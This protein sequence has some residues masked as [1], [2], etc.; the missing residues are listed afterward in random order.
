[1]LLATLAASDPVSPFS[2]FIAPPR[3]PPV[4]PEEHMELQ[5]QPSIASVLSSARLD[6]MVVV[7]VVVVVGCSLEESVEVGVCDVGVKV[8]VLGESQ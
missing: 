3:V 5:S 2:L 1:M 6:G 7:V 4:S 8:G